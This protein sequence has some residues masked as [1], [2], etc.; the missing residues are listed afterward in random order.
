MTDA[1]PILFTCIEDGCFVPAGPHWAKKAREHYSVGEKYKLVEHHDRSSASHRY[2]FSAVNATWENLPDDLLQL[3]PSPTILRKKML[4]KAGF[5]T[6][7]SIVCSSKAEAIR[8]AAFIGTLD[9][10]AVVVPRG[11]VVSVYTA[12]SQRAK[13]MD[14]ERFKASADAVLD[15]MAATLGVTAKELK[16]S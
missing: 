12:E 8:I 3:Y 6:E 5:C 1:P 15:I 10:Y 7:R 9:Q 13:A 4:I 11:A 14:K 2:F 16:A